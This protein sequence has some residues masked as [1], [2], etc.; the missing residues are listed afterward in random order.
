MSSIIQSKSKVS[1]DLK[2][3]GNILLLFVM[4]GGD[5]KGLTPIKDVNAERSGTVGAIF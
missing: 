1:P 5:I 2:D 4:M 3:W